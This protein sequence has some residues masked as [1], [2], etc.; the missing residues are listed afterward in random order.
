MDAPNLTLSRVAV[1]ESCGK[2]FPPSA[3]VD[4]LAD[5]DVR[6]EAVDA[7][8]TYD[9]GDAVVAFGPRPGFLDAG[10]VHCIR[11]GYDEF[12]RDAYAD[13]GVILTNSTGIHGTA[14]GETVAGYMLQFA[15][16]LHVFRDA[17]NDREWVGVPYEDAFTLD[18]E[19]LCVVGLGTL[20]TGIAERA[21][22]LGMDVV[23][24]RRSG[25]PHDAARKV[26]APD[27]LRD[28]VADARFVAL[29]TPLTDET[30]GMV[31]AP[32]FEAMRDDAYL[33]NVSRGAVVDEPALVE[34]LESGEIAGAGLD[35]FAEE[36]LP[37]DS[38][39]WGFEEVIVTPHRGAM[40]R[41]Y[42]ADVADLV[43]ENV[44]R[45]DAGEAMTNRVA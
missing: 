20:G 43:R 29:A 7:G 45:L 5:L 2:V 32:E 37:D 40:T 18:G 16:R 36:P 3:L 12:D 24:V 44:R 4:A 31:G 10:W 21:A 17:Q 34:A 19:T 14:I 8:A 30:E 23:G 13:A 35:A 22:G 27:R 15:R 11:A 41:T 26:Y 1:H 9:D 28:A 42:H 25:D 6:V 33:L 39:M 38:P